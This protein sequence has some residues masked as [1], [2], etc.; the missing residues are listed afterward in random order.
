MFRTLCAIA[1]LGGLAEVASAGD[2]IRRCVGPDGN[3]IYTDQPCA[4]FDAVDRT[5][6]PSPPA[7][8]NRQGDPVT[9]RSDCARRTDT[10]LFELRRAIE[11]QN[12]NQLAGLYH[13]PGISGRGA[14]GIMQRLQQLVDRPQASVELVFPDTT[15]V[16][17]MPE[18][19]PAGTPPEDPVG[20]R[21]AVS[22]PGEF[23]AGVGQE[24]RLVQHAG[25]WWVSF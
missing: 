10:L 24:L 12:V 2:G 16:L 13:W 19:F 6:P 8:T 11:S 7:A 14:R 25:C 20:V 3:S 4:Q 5:P 22:L 21:I 23:S 9:V 1:L 18:A 17:D 15:P